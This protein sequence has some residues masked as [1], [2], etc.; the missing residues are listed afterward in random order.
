[1]IRGTVRGIGYGLSLIR[2]VFREFIADDCIGFASSLA[3]FTLFSFPPIVAL[4]VDIASL[5]VGPEMA[6]GQLSV[7]LGELVGVE[8]AAQAQEALVAL[9]QRQLDRPLARLGSIGLLLFAATMVLAQ[10]QQALNRVW[11]VAPASGLTRF[12]VKRVVSIA[13][14]LVLVLLLLG[15]LL[16]SAVLGAVGPQLDQFLPETATSAVINSANAGISF[17]A[18]TLVTI[19]LLKLLP[20][21]KIPWSDA[22]IGGM[23]TAVLLTLG[24]E[25]ISF[26]VSTLSMGSSFGAARSLALLLFWVFY[27]SGIVLWGAEFTK[28]VCRRRGH[29]APPA[30]GV[31]RIKRQ[32]RRVARRVQRGLR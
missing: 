30:D 31:K 27:S 32:A 6:Q 3:F 17:G 20:E 16:V 29:E 11:N 18:M 1:M 19:A 24:Q 22:A 5:A 2:E 13:V 28:V 4:V 8:V 15:S 12:F 23:V 7:I 14:I 10:L 21:V 9:R 26:I 25:V